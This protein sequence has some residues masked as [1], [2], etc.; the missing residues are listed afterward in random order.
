MAK[1][2]R[3]TKQRKTMTGAPEA[4]PS[5]TSPVALPTP[6]IPRLS[7]LTAE[8][9]TRQ[10][11]Q[12]R[13]RLAELAVAFE[14]LVA[15]DLAVRRNVDEDAVLLS[16]WLRALVIA[17]ARKE[18][19][20]FGKPDGLDSYI[21]GHPDV[22]GPSWAAKSLP[23]AAIFLRSAVRTKLEAHRSD[24]SIREQPFVVAEELAEL[25]TGLVLEAPDLIWGI[26]RYVPAAV[27]R[28][29][30]RT[31]A[32][33]AIKELLSD[34]A[35]NAKLDDLAERIVRACMRALGYPG[36]KTKNLFEADRKR[37]A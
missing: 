35:S 9:I 1:R 11:S 33:A 16:K 24:G 21:A 7:E 5:A 26:L 30:A 37:G 15:E 10:H 2:T 36:N 25:V 6:S 34:A 28:A 3:S 32:T 23:D 8:E 17:D 31:M 20:R 22:G 14:E 4:R 13:A 12:L 27:E 29:S 19:S 18:V